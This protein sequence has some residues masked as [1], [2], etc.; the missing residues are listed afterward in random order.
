MQEGKLYAL[1]AT[2]FA[3]V[4]I[5]ANLLT[6]KLVWLP[7][8]E[9]GMPCGVLLYP[10]ASLLTNLT[11]ERFGKVLAKRM[12]VQGLG[13]SLLSAVLLECA[14]LLPSADLA[15]QEMLSKLLH[16]NRASILSSAAAFLVGQF[17]DVTLYCSIR[18]W[19]G[20]KY[21][22]LRN[23]GATGPSL[24]VD[25]LI[26]N[27]LLFGLILGEPIQMVAKIITLS[28]FYKMS[29]SLLLAPFYGWIA[30]KFSRVAA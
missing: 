21:L 19:T 20:G 13:I 23:L 1:L 24:L 2:L 5:L 6:A 7:G 16:I 17:L 29:A 18:Q 25:T 9:T 3:V 27:I 12:V 22:L 8:V 4:V 28:F 14:L 10:L 30:P 15:S 26:V 11:A